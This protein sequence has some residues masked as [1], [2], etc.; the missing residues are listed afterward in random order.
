MKIKF[1]WKIW[2]LLLVLALSL[3]S[4]IG[5]PPM[6]MQKG[7]V[8]TNIDSNSTAFSQGLREGQIIISIDGRQIKTIEDFSSIVESKFSVNETIKWDIVTS[9]LEAIFLTDKSPVITVSPHPKTN[10]KF[11]L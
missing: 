3:I 5:L 11:G 1:T 7:V 9:G 10:L 4:I 2:L 6:F 8:I